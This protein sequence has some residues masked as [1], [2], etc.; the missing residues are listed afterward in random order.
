MC[1]HYT[2]VNT[3][4]NIRYVELSSNSLEDLVCEE[5][6]TFE[7]LLKLRNLKEKRNRVF[8]PFQRQVWS[9]STRL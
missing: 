9:E 7:S 8:E 3:P 4:T 5:N 6:F 1:T 2:Q